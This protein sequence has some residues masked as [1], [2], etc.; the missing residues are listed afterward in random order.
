MRAEADA[1]TAMSGGLVHTCASDAAAS[2]L[3]PRWPKKMASIDVSAMR[4]NVA[5][6]TCAAMDVR[7][8]NSA[9]TEALGA[10][11]AGFCLT[12]PAPRSSSGLDSDTALLMAP[13]V[14][15]SSLLTGGWG[16][17]EE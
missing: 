6:L 3:T 4:A 15:S 14:A 10:N 2:C 12:S 9:H 16:R 5:R 8:T 13:G 11:A 1:Q 17:R 7:L